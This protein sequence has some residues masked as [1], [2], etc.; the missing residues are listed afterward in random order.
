MCSL[1]CQL[2]WKSRDEYENS[3]SKW[4]Q[5]KE[6]RDTDRLCSHVEPVCNERVQAHC[7]RRLTEVT[8]LKV[9]VGSLQQAA[10]S[11]FH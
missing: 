6:V 4:V 1:N 8:E 2:Y 10:L 11:T 7:K 3:V 5:L 9:T